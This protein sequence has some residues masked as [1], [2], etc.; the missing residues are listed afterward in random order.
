[1]VVTPS[2]RAL[3]A[4]YVIP[5]GRE[6]GGT[7]DGRRDRHDHRSTKW[8]ERPSVVHFSLTTAKQRGHLSDRY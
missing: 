1:M 8:R 4:Q 3:C 5:Q 6:K 7:T 2:A